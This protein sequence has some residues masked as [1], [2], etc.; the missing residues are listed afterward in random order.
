MMKQ[1]RAFT[2]IMAILTASVMLALGYAIFNIVSKEILL[3]SSGRESQFA[4]FAADTGIEC[5][6]YWDS[7]FD[8]FSTSSPLIE[9]S[10]GVASSTLTK[11]ISGNNAT[12]TFSFQFSTFITRPCVTV[13]VAKSIPAKTKIESAGY[14]TC[15]VTNP[16][17][18]ERAIR[19]TY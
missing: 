9:V 16:R 17:R 7:K 15:V 14:N 1:P 10:C 13:T 3:S 5:A 19:V 12:S 4:F 11:V 18:I 6:L 2:L 8:A